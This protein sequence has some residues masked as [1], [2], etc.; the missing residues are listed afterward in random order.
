MRFFIPLLFFV[1]TGCMGAARTSLPESDKYHHYEIAHGRSMASAYQATELWMA[2]AFTSAKS[3]VDM[4]QPESG[5]IIAK[6]MASWQAGG[7]MGAKKYTPYFLQIVN[8]D[9]STTVDIT[10][11]AS[12]GAWSGYPSEGEMRRIKAEFDGL[13]ASLQRA[14]Q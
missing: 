4:K 8:K 7:S 5:T 14:L 2:R 13:A 11:G 6:P 12:S 10:F 1:L 9:N 3:V